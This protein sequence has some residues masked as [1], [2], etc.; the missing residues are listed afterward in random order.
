MFF[1]LIWSPFPP[2]SFMNVLYLRANQS[3]ISL[4]QRTATITEPL[5]NHSF[6]YH[7]T[8]SNVIDGT[9]LLTFVCL[10]FFSLNVPQTNENKIVNMSGF[11]I[12]C[13]GTPITLHKDTH[14][15]SNALPTWDNEMACRVLNPFEPRSHPAAWLS[16]HYSW[17]KQSP[18]DIDTHCAC[19][20]DAASSFIFQTHFENAACSCVKKDTFLQ[21]DNLFHFADEPVPQT[22]VE[23]YVCLTY[24]VHLR[25]AGHR[26]I[27]ARLQAMAQQGS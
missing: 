4:T 22:W 19:P 5:S 18:F 15:L 14:R 13:H 6:S 12:L 27:K 23:G 7:Q 9:P 20:L 16:C 17:T 3:T 26:W 8:N 1:L 2:S 24:Y 21:T 25:T 11:R 10:F